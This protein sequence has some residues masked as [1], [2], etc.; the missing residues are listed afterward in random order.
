MSDAGALRSPACELSIRVADVDTACRRVLDL[1]EEY[2]GTA[3]V[4]RLEHGGANLYVEV[5]SANAADLLT[6]ALPLD[7]SGQEHALP[8]F[9]G[10]GMTLVL[11]TLVAE[12]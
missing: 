2:E 6:A 9:E 3:D 1:V 5:P 4:Q 10:D 12:G 8:G 7:T 11:V